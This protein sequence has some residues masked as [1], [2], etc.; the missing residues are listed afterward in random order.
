MNDSR[1]GIRRR[2]SLASRADRHTLYEKAV[3]GVEAEIDF[4]DDTFRK[5]RKRRASLLREDFCGTGNT[6]CEWVRR[7]RDNQAVGVDIDPAVLAWG[8][9]NT[10]VRL[11][12]AQRER[13][14]LCQGDVLRF[15]G[16]EPDIVLAMNFS[17]WCFKE[18]RTLGAYF[19]K[20]HRALASDGVFFLDTWGGSDAFR[21][22][23]ERR[24]C[25]H[26]TYIWEQEHYDP[27]TGDLRCHIHFSFRDGS[28]LRRAFS[29]DW[30]LW[31][32]PELRELLVEAGFARVHVYW[33]V[34]DE[35]EGDFRPV[36]QGDAD[37]GWVSYLVAEK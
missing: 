16:I 31:T 15:N 12:P 35:G 24:K 27:V 19:R 33:D 21:E 29:Y 5:L 26:F 23:R 10:L 14:R 13:I 6:S 22:M 4:V 8:R 11:K 36:Q 17:Y 2:Q 34:S 37:L 32:L 28:R 30:R 25:G 20:V 3:Q 9:D 7:R 18:R 1:R